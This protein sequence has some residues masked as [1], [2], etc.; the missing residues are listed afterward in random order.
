MIGRGLISSSSRSEKLRTLGR[1]CSRVTLDL[2]TKGPDGKNLYSSSAP[3]VTDFT[4]EPTVCPPIKAKG[5]YNPVRDYRAYPLK[6]SL[7]RNGVYL[8]ER[9]APPCQRLK[10]ATGPTGTLGT[11]LARKRGFCVDVYAFTR[12]D[13]VLSRPALFVE[14]PRFLAM[15]R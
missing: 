15:S 6:I 11:S 12:V 14:D 9:I 3:V 2:V 13:G 4:C 7:K 5:A 8:P 10:G 1:Q